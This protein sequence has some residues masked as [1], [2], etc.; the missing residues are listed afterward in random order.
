[1]KATKTDQEHRTPRI[2]LW[3]TVDTVQK[4]TAIK[5]LRTLAHQKIRIPLLERTAPDQNTNTNLTADQIG[6][7]LSLSAAILRA[8]PGKARRCPL[9]SKCR[10]MQ[11]LRSLA[12]YI[13]A[14][15]LDD[16]FPSDAG[17]C[18]HGS[19]PIGDR[20]KNPRAAAYYT[21]NPWNVR[22]S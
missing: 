22:H 1:M 21:A 14:L 6:K 4:T 13:A 8:A 7:N 9:S 10:L 2:H 12:G 3:R 19:R 20:A 5:I 11:A 15:P 18:K 17:S 16:C